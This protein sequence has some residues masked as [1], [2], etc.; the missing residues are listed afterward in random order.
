MSTQ[1]GRSVDQLI[2]QLSSSLKPVKSVNLSVLLGLWIV[3]LFTILLVWILRVTPSLSL[4]L[5]LFSWVG[6]GV[7]GLFISALLLARAAL[8]SG[9]PGR[10]KHVNRLSTFVLT[11][12]A[13]WIGF[14]AFQSILEIFHGHSTAHTGWPCSETILTYSSPVLVCGFILLKRLF[15]QRHMITCALMVLAA[16]LPI[17]GTMFVYCPSLDGGHL[18]VWHVAVPCILLSAFYGVGSILYRKIK[19]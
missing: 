11:P 3:A 5:R 18:L 7:V 4:Q 1:P 10:E 8:L 14:L 15:P 6:I 19:A 16:L 13:L 17:L 2:G 12:A 9:I